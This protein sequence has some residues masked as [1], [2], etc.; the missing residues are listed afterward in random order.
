MK[1]GR[2]RS[3][4]L[5]SRA[6]CAELTLRRHARH[7]KDGQLLHQGRRSILRQEALAKVTF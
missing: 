4:R 6:T 7:H 2:E 3:T 1:V 5:S